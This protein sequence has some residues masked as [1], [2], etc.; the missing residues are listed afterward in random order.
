[1]KRSKLQRSQVEAL[2]SAL[3]PPIRR[4]VVDELRQRDQRI[5]ALESE[6]KSLKAKITKMMRKST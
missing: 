5:A 1:M 4:F 6:Q 2:I 3:I